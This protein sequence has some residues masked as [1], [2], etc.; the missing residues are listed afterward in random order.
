MYCARNELGADGVSCTTLVANCIRF[1]RLVPAFTAFLKIKNSHDKAGDQNSKFK[2]TNEQDMSPIQGLGV[3]GFATQGG[4]LL[5][6]GLRNGG[7]LGLRQ[8]ITNRAVL[9]SEANIQFC[10]VS[11][12]FLENRS[13][14]FGFVRLRSLGGGTP[15]AKIPSGLSRALRRVRS[16]SVA[17]LVV[18]GLPETFMASTLTRRRV[19]RIQGL[20]RVSACQHISFLLCCS[21]K[22]SKQKPNAKVFPYLH[23]PSSN[24]L[25]P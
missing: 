24:H 25:N 16:P 1:Y 8:W 19:Q 12:A 22:R 17:S 4:A 5:C 13:L 9:D 11:F 21:R 2:M 6:P 14:T 3:G 20:N 23:P 18:S 15:S 7:P 10:P